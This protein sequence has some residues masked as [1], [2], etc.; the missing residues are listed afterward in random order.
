MAVFGVG[1][2]FIA[3]YTTL[4]LKEYGAASTIAEEIISS[5]KTAQA[6][7][8]QSKLTKLYDDSLVAAQRAGYRLKFS[9]A[10]MLACMFFSVYAFYGLGFCMFLWN[11]SNVGEGSKLL[12]DNDLDAGTVLTVLFAVIIGA[13]SLGSLGPRVE[14]FAKASSAAR[15]IFQTLQRIP[16]IDSFDPNGEKPENIKGN[17]EFRNVSFIYPARPQGIPSPN[18]LI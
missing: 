3:K 14:A 12:A 15:K 9:S 13:F 11:S 4:Q 8:T 17:I 10:V 2:T 6:F 16:T 18:I 7:G 1:G 5:V